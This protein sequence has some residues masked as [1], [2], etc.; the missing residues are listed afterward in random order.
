[1]SANSIYYRMS[2]RANPCRES[3]VTVAGADAVPM[4]WDFFSYTDRLENWLRCLLH[5]PTEL[6]FSVVNCM[7]CMLYVS[8]VVTKKNVEAKSPSLY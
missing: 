3:S 2:G 5:N 6:C 8:K 1:M 7:A 4:A